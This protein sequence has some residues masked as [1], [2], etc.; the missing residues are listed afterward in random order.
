MKL[1]KNILIPSVITLCQLL[2]SSIFYMWQGGF[3]GGHGE[4]DM[5]VAWSLIPGVFFADSIPYLELFGF[6]DYISL[7]VIS[8]L[9]N[10]CGFFIVLKL[11]SF[12]IRL[13][14]RGVSSN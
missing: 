7:I 4:F 12:I 13:W 14:K 6:G 5:I 1:K 11:L 9:L 10:W 3:G 8:C 2:V